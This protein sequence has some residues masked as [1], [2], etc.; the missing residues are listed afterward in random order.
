MNAGR[1]I[2]V[3]DVHGCVIEFLEL[4]EKLEIGPRDRVICLGDFM[5]KGPDPLG[6]LRLAMARGFEC[7]AANHEERHARWW[8][9][10]KR[11]R[12]TGV[13]NAMRPWHDDRDRAANEDL[14]E[15]EVVWMESRPPWIEIQPGWVAVHG[16]FQPGIAL[17]DQDPKKVV[18][19]RW[20]DT[21]GEHVPVDYDALDRKPADGVSHWTERWTGPESVVYGHEAF[22]L[23]DPLV[24]IYESLE[25][26]KTYCDGK[27][28][29]VAPKPHT[30][31]R[32][33]TWGIDTGCVHGGHLSALIFP[34]LE[35]VQVKAREV[36]LDPPMPIPGGEER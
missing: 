31:R 34:T 35:L 32:V 29:E 5:D 20:M 27:L 21:E 3:G 36:Y 11:F 14:R 18:R 16:G 8:R 2:V 22:H 23:K 19:L 24:R 6:C 10:E 9:C 13:P 26:E 17:A 28:V 30:H 4:L 25:L 15:D 33:E 12:E 1:A 7:V